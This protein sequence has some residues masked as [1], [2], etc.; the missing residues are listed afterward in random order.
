MPINSEY[1][2]V[3]LLA[4]ALSER[5]A[6]KQERAIELLKKVID[7]CEKSDS[8]TCQYVNRTAHASLYHIYQTLGQNS[9]AQRYYKKA[10][11]LGAG[12]EELE[13]ID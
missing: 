6:G 13:G 8:G 7:I 2:A 9:E 10:I 3:R 12:K 1:E 11:K 5:D 4:H